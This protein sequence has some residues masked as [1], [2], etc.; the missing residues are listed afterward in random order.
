M[1]LRKC[2]S[3]MDFGAG[4][5]KDCDVGKIRDGDTSVWY[6]LKAWETVRGVLREGENETKNN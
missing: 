1:V 4:S 6:E 3:V 5:V 2:G